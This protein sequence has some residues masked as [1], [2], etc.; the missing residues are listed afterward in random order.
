LLSNMLTGI[1][2]FLKGK[3]SL[4]SKKIPNDGEIRIIQKG[5]GEK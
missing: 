4:S 5:I 2:F 1:R 3:I